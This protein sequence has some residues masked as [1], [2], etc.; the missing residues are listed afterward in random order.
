[1][2]SFNILTNNYPS[3]RRNISE[4]F[5]HQKHPGEF[6]YV[7]VSYNWD[8]IKSKHN[9]NPIRS[10]THFIT[11]QFKFRCIF[12]ITH[13]PETLV[14]LTGVNSSVFITDWSE[15][16]INGTYV[17]EMHK[18]LW[19]LLLMEFFQNAIFYSEGTGW[20][21]QQIQSSNYV[22]SFQIKFVANKCL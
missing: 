18:A 22:K 8:F 12:L 11:S 19:P 5:D 13:F 21:C 15:N 14:S 4:H 10:S 7:Q 17:Y 3:I 6:L 2:W 9:L 16:F 20:C 1:M